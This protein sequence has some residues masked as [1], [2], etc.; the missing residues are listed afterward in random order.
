[1]CFNNRSNTQNFESLENKKV[2]CGIRPK[3][4]IIEDKKSS[5]NIEGVMEVSE[6]LGEETLIRKI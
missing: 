1:M 4:F 3:D 2:Y 6:M 5:S